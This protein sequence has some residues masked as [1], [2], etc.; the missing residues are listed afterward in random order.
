MPWIMIITIVLLS[1]LDLSPAAAAVNAYDSG[2]DVTETSCGWLDPGPPPL[3]ASH[4]SF[5]QSRPDYI[6]VNVS[7]PDAWMQVF[8]IIDADGVTVYKCP[9]NLAPVKA[10]CPWL[11]PGGYTLIIEP[12]IITAVPQEYILTFSHAFPAPVVAATKPA[13]GSAFKSTIEIQAI[14]APIKYNPEI[15]AIE[16]WSEGCLLAQSSEVATPIEIDIPESFGQQPELEIRCLGKAGGYMSRMM[17]LRRIMDS[18]SEYLM[19][20]SVFNFDFVDSQYKQLIPITVESAGELWLSIGGD[21]AWALQAELAEGSTVLARS[22]F[23]R[24]AFKQFHVSVI[25][26]SYILRI[27][28]LW[29]VAPINRFV[30]C[31]WTTPR[32]KPELCCQCTRQVFDPSGDMQPPADRV[33]MTIFDRPSR[34]IEAN[35]TDSLGIEV[36]GPIQ[37]VL[38]ERGIGSFEWGAKDQNGRIVGEGNYYIKIYNGVAEVSEGVEVRYHMANQN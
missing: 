33:Q 26:G 1:V 11:N 3:S 25:S 34:E 22:A 14:P 8:R 4:H 7:G 17:R 13:D 36:Y 5:F 27:S 28:K 20:S 24:Q 15:A 35:V 19:T 21:C 6:S 30:T 10:Y 31:T 12:M 18:D 38:D 29:E 9:E 37:I 16:I 23:D 32:R 2:N